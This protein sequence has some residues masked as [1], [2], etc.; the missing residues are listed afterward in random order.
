MATWR[1]TFSD[2][3]DTL[4]ERWTNITGT[5]GSADRPTV[6]GGVL[7]TQLY[8]VLEHSS[9]ITY[10]PN[11]LYRCQYT[12]SQGAI[13]GSASLY[14]GITGIRSNG[15]TRCNI[16]GS[17]TV[18]AQHYFA[19]RA[20]TTPTD[21]MTTFTGY[22]MGL[23]SAPTGNEAPDL[24]QPGPAHEL[25]AFFRPLMYLGYNNTNAAVSNVDRVLFSRV[26]NA[27]GL[28]RLMTADGV[29]VTWT[30][31]QAWETEEY[32]RSS[33]TL[34]I[35]E[36]ASPIVLTDTLQSPRSTVTFLTRTQ[37]DIA[38]L[39]VILADTRPITLTSPCPSVPSGT[40]MVIGASKNR[41]TNRGDDFRMLWEVELQEVVTVP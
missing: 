29:A 9:N 24:T 28:V 17:N 6:A 12:A 18:S 19:A 8:T 5:G 39:L 13:T 23:S 41:L 33:S 20:R 25:V 1:G 10:T 15:T 40:Y 21:Q 27:A 32:A 7:T 16:A 26:D 35:I 2:S 31:I 14:F 11:T 37:Q 34:R 38:D 22:F 36:R 30:E 4:D 3:F